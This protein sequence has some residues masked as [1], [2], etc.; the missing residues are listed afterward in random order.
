[1]VY[2]QDFVRRY[3]ELFSNRDM[4]CSKCNE[5]IQGV[6]DW[7]NV[8]HIQ[9]DKTCYNCLATL[10]SNCRRD[11]V[12]H[13]GDVFSLTRYTACDKTYCTDC[14][15]VT[16]CASCSDAYCEGL[17]EMEE[18]DGRENVNCKHCLYSCDSCHRTRCTDCLDY[19]YCKGRNRI[20]QNCADCYS[21]EYSS[22]KYCREC[23]HGAGECCGGCVGDVVPLLLQQVEDM[24]KPVWARQLKVLYCRPHPPS[25]QSANMDPG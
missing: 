5:D 24:A 22:V 15:S 1:M 23:Q 14:V 8:Y 18:C 20:N 17:G 25:F 19:H 12:F 7:M 4:I 2:L 21:E 16:R 6:S 3:N 11:D 13:G 9:N 10:C